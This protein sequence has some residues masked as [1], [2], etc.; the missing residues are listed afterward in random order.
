MA[1]EHPIVPE[2]QILPPPGAVATADDEVLP[3]KQAAKRLGLSPETLR[4]QIHAGKIHATLSGKT[5][6]VTAP[7]VARCGKRGGGDDERRTHEHTLT[8]VR[9]SNP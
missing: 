3:R 6:L 4:L 7:G 8:L 2:G 1:R 9:S 5:C